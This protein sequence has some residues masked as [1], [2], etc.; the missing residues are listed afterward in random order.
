MDNKNLNTDLFKALKKWRF[1]KA[2][3]QN[4]PAYLILTDCALKN[5]ATYHPSCIGNLVLL[6]GMG[7]ITAQK[8]GE[9]ILLIVMRYPGEDTTPQPKDLRW[10]HIGML[11][12][13]LDERGLEPDW[14][15]AR[16]LNEWRDMVAQSI[17]CSYFYVFS[18]KALAN[19]CVYCPITIAA[20]NRIPGVTRNTIEN[21]GSDIIQQ[22]KG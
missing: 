13:Q 10:Q 22:I 11:L 19:L 8:Y 4:V 5:I 17:G 18:D 21:Y 7:E 3:E 6:K 2:A 12:R 9:E 16:K 14:D 15:L 1:D 20:L